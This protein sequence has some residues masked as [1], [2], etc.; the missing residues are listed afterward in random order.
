MALPLF[1]CSI[2]LQSC[3]LF[4]SFRFGLLYIYF[5]INCSF[6]AKLLEWGFHS[7][8]A[9]FDAPLPRPPSDCGMLQNLRKSWTTRGSRGKM[10]T[11]AETRVRDSFSPF[12]SFIG[13]VAAASCCCCC[14]CC[15]WG[16]T[17]PLP[18][19]NTCHKRQLWHLAYVC[20]GFSINLSSPV[21]C[22]RDIV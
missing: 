7:K 13:I 18:A 20:N 4:V 10:E 8:W 2:V 3:L 1:V 15:G 16:N 22:S 14:C 6:V 17:S 19:Q 21:Y 9:G 11:H 5:K 12:C